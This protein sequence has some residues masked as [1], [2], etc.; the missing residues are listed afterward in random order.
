MPLGKLNCTYITLGW[1]NIVQLLSWS[2]NSSRIWFKQRFITFT[3]KAIHFSP[4]LRQIQPF[5]TPAYPISLLSAL[6]LS[7]HLQFDLPS[8]HFRVCPSKL[9]IRFFFPP[10]P[11]TFLRSHSP[12]YNPINN[13]SC[14]MKVVK[15][16]ITPFP[17][18]SCYFLRCWSHSSS[19][20]FGVHQPHPVAFYRHEAKLHSGTNKH[21]R[22]EL[23]IS[24][25][26][27]F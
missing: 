16:F 13:R 19:Q 27:L 1:Q 2:N 6:I 12:L 17:L 7:S 4:I 24:W 20:L 3:K 10:M 21:A 8:G 23:H 9:C 18:A 26:L 22:L 14:A 15:L 5:A 25:P 11:L